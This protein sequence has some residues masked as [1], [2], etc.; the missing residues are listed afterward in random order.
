MRRKFDFEYTRVASIRLFSMVAV[1]A[2]FA[3]TIVPIRAFGEDEPTFESLDAYD[4]MQ[5]G[6]Q[7]LKQ[8][9]AETALRA[10]DRV[11]KLMP[12]A[13][14]V[15]FGKGIGQYKLNRFD[16]ARRAFEQAALS[17][18]S[19]LAADAQ[20]G[21][22]A[23]HHAQALAMM[24][25][26]DPQNPEQGKETLSH[27]ESAMQQYRRVLADH[28]G[29]K[30]SREADL[31]AAHLWRQLKQQ[32]QQQQQQSGD[33][34]DDKNDEEKENE[35]KKE[36]GEKKEDQKNEQDDQSKE[37]QEK[38][39][40]SQQDQQDEQKEQKE[41]NAN[42][43]K[44]S[45]EKQPSQSEENK[46]QEA[47]PAQAEKQEEREAKEQADRRLRELMQTLKDR[48]KSRKQQVQRPVIAPPEKDW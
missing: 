1:L 13:R 5:K 28:S 36:S 41:S 23:A 43:K 44:E 30:A 25:S 15:P 31:K 2:F 9:E 32:Q 14:E 11:E 27:L 8:G 4:A 29:H 16:E 33:K 38:K 46:E 39:E 45:E 35:D 3:T 24:S 20:Y 12:D 40:S 7:L 21:I 10:Y 34:S 26:P 17:R 42:E 6:N 18:D 37:N 22:G 47:Q 19:K 48:Q